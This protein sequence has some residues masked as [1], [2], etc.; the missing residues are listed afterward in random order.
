[1]NAEE[2]RGL[3]LMEPCE[4]PA[5][6]LRL[7]V[8]EN[9]RETAATMD[10][11]LQ[12]LGYEVRVAHDGRTAVELSRRDPP[13]VALLD[14]GLPEMDGYEVARQL[15]EQWLPKRPLLIAVTGFGRVEDRQRS[16][17]AG[18]DLHM[19]KPLNA[20]RLMEVLNTFQRFVVQ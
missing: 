10:R 1:M 4:E 18:I 3:L 6:P 2:F 13:D 9:H 19:T 7:L 16:E 11:L 15:R 14:I 5:R 20:A 17:E 8:V 12:T